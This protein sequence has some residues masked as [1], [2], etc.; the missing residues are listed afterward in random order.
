MPLKKETLKTIYTP[1]SARPYEGH[2]GV[3][4]PDN[5]HVFDIKYRSKFLI[6]GQK[7]GFG[8]RRRT[9]NKFIHSQCLEKERYSTGCTIIDALERAPAPSDKTVNFSFCD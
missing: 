9:F 8:W 6:G 3:V 1:V 4:R 5:A 2:P 7:F